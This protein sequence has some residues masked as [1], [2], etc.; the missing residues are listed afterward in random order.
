MSERRACQ[1]VNQP[2][3]TLRDG[4]CVRLRP[5]RSNHVWSYDFVGAKT[6]DGRAARMLDLID[7]RAREYLRIRCERNWSSA[8]GI[9]ALADLVEIKCVPEHLRSDCGDGLSINPVAL[10]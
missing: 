4:S 1:L 6:Q 9:S 5:E 8:R 7:D 3:D 2:R 10:R